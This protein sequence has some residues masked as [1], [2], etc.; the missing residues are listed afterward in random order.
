MLV[1]KVREEQARMYALVSAFAHKVNLA[2]VCVVMSGL[3]VGKVVFASAEL[4]VAG[5]DF[6]AVEQFLDAD[7]ALADELVL[8]IRIP[9]AKKWKKR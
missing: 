4:A 8:L 2:T 7:E 6:S 1:A 9:D 3:V 5:L